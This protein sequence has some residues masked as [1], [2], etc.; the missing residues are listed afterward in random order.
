MKNRKTPSL[1][2]S[3]AKYFGWGDLNDMVRTSALEVCRMF[4]V[5]FKE[6][7]G[8]MKHVNE[9]EEGKKHL[10]RS[11]E[12]RR[13]GKRWFL[14]LYDLLEI[15][16]FIL[17]Y[18]ELDQSE[19]EAAKLAKGFVDYQKKI[20]TAFRNYQPR[21]EPDL[22]NRNL[23]PDA[24]KKIKMQ[25]QKAQEVIDFYK[26]YLRIGWGAMLRTAMLYNK[27]HID[28][29]LQWKVSLELRDLSAGNKEE[30]NVHSLIAKLRQEK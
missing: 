26:P 1:S 23:K 18:K 9:A 16:L 11:K 25:H 5:T 30:E 13:E 22:K 17:Y 27:E 19:K 20:H 21:I 28:E 2:L 6:F 8:I 29:G 14:N 4:G 12:G 10:G 3:T 24:R 7:Q 15:S